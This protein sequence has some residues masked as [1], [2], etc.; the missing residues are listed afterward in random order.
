[1]DVSVSVPNS[2]LDNVYTSS[3]TISEELLRTEHEGVRSGAT[4]LSLTKEGHPDKV[5]Q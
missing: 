1:M 3:D 4:F 5:A 2:A